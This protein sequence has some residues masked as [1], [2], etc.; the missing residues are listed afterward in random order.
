M[1]GVSDTLMFTLVARDIGTAEHRNIGSEP[2]RASALQ[3]AG[4]RGAEQRPFTH[5]HNRARYSASRVEISSL[6][7]TAGDRAPC[8]GGIRQAIAVG[9]TV[10]TSG[11]AGGWY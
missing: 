3:G 10:A 5:T 1:A 8:R 4:P 9:V 2:A 7:G 11:G 6:Y